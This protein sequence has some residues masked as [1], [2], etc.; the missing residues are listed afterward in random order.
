MTFTASLYPEVQAYLASTLAYFRECGIE[1]SEDF[2]QNAM[3]EIHY[4]K[5]LINFFARLL[6]RVR[7]KVVFLVYYYGLVEMALVSACAE[8]QI[9]SVDIQHGVQGEFHPAYGRWGRIPPTGFDALPSIFW[10]WSK[11]EATAIAHWS[12]ATAGA[13]TPYIGGNLF[14]QM[15]RDSQSAVVQEYELQVRQHISAHATVCVLLTLQTDCGGLIP[16]FIR[17]I[18]ESPSSWFWWIRLHPGMRK[19]LPTVEAQGSVLSRDRY[20]LDDATLI[21]IHSILRICQAHI[22]LYSSTVL[23]AEQF[24]VKSMICHQTGVNYFP[25]QLSNG[26]AM[27]CATVEEALAQLAVVITEHSQAD[28]IQSQQPAGDTLGAFFDRYY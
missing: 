24:G 2:S 13:H 9:C 26:S 15:F 12:D 7:P 17:I 22:T 8:Q 23:E 21:P 25:E 11:E 16:L 6:Q 4:Y 14:L 27:F 28:N 1:F 18:Q 19:D 5:T 20:Y 10:C 3:K